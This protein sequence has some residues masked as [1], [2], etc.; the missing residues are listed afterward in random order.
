VSAGRELPRRYSICPTSVIPLRA[1][2]HARSKDQNRASLEVHVNRHTVALDPRTRSAF[3]S[4]QVATKRGTILDVAD[5]KRERSIANKELWPVLS[6]DLGLAEADTSPVA[7]S[8]GARCR[9][10]GMLHLKCTNA[11]RCKEGEAHGQAR[12]LKPKRKPGSLRARNSTR[13]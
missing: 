12:Y 13:G 1:I 6:G 3:D 5:K 11:A 4:D 8:L 9:M 2:R 10:P 7:T